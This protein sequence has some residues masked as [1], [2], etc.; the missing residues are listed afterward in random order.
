MMKEGFLESATREFRRIKRT[1]EGA[2]EQLDEAQFFAR[3]GDD[4]NPTALLVKHMAGN[5][6]S[7]WTQFLTSDG[8]KPDRNRDGEFV[9]SDN[10][11][12]EHLLGAWEQGWQCLFEMLA[13]LGEGDLAAEVRIRGESFSVLQAIARQLTHYAYHTGQIVLLARHFAGS[14][15]KTLSVARGGSAAFNASPSPYLAEGAPEK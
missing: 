10:D 11:T 14:R 8:E 15:W 5:M 13:Q 2:M 3:L 7:R 12:R 9:L 4:D 1:A 6:K